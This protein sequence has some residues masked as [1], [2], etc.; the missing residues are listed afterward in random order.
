M[1]KLREG[2][3]EQ[4]I[5]KS[6]DG[7]GAISSTGQVHRRKSQIDARDMKLYHVRSISPRLGDY[8]SAGNVSE[9]DIH[10]CRVQ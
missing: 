9:D 3:R 5:W 2:Q 7:N 10:S 6:Q 4:I 8:G 1:S